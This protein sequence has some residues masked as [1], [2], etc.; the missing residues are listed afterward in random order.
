MHDVGDV[1]VIQIQWMRVSKSLHPLP[2]HNIKPKPADNLT[3][4]VSNYTGTGKVAA[5]INAN[6]CYFTWAMPIAPSS[7]NFA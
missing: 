2:P 1:I 3:T 7:P 4:F 6:L 5:S